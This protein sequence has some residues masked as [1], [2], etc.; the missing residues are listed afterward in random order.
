MK[1]VF[2]SFSHCSI[3]LI[4]CVPL[5]FTCKIRGAE[6]L[7]PMGIRCFSDFTVKSEDLNPRKRGRGG[8]GGDRDFGAWCLTAAAA[9]GGA[10]AADGGGAKNSSRRRSK[11][12][13]GRRGRIGE[14]EREREQKWSS[15]LDGEKWRSSLVFIG[16]EGGCGEE[17]D[18]GT[19]R[20]WLGMVRGG[21]V[22]VSSQDWSSSAA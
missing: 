11:V 19:A 3:R 8:R 22:C 7:N 1:I 12:N 14:R 10:R 21:D 4:Y 9:K 6:S 20:H 16:V 2:C 18:D 15:D 17:V 5:P 13:G